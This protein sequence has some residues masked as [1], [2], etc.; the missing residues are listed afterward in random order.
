MVELLK[1]MAIYHDWDKILSNVS[2]NFIPVSFDELKEGDIVMTS[3]FTY[4]Q[5]Y[6]MY[7]GYE[8]YNM[9]KI[10]VLLTKNND[11]PSAS[12]LFMKTYWDDNEE[13]EEEEEEFEQVNLYSDPGSSGGFILYKY[14]K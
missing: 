4:S 3:T 7:A 6:L 12:N 1:S 14:N 8:E 11:N 13:E 9:K 10:G 2:K 5:K